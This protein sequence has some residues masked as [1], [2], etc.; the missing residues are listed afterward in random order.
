MA[1]LIAIGK[2]EKQQWWQSI[3]EGEEVL[4]GRAPRTGWS[5]PWDRLISREHAY[6][7][8][9]DDQLE[10]RELDTA[11]NPIFFEG[12]QRKQFFVD[13]DC[14]FRIGETTFRF[15]LHQPDPSHKPT[16]VEHTLARE[17]V[18]TP[19]FQNA[20]SCLEALC[21]MPKMIQGART[22]VEFASQI[23]DLLLESLAGAVA[24][25]VM[26]YEVDDAAEV[27]DPVLMRWNSREGAV[28]R[29]RPSRRLVNRAFDKK[30]S[31]M[32]LWTEA[33][34][35][36][37]QFTMNDD[38][39]WAFC[40]PIATCSNERWCLYVSGKRQFTGIQDVESPEDLMGE[41][42]LAELMAH[43][44]GAIRNLR[45]LEHQHSSMKQFFS[46]AV[47]ETLVSKKAELALEPRE[48][49]VSVLFCDIRGFSRKVE[50]SREELPLLLSRVSEAL[51]V[52]T[53]SILKFE[54]VI[55]DFQGDAAL[56]FWGWPTEMDDS[57]VHACRAALAIQAAFH[58]A[59][60]DPS[61]PL[62]GFQIGIGVGHGNAVAGR[63]GSQEQIKVGVFG[64]V[65]NLA[66]RLQDLTKAMGVP[67]LVD[68]QTAQVA[69]KALDAS[70]AYC[71]RVAYL[72]PAGVQSSVNAYALIPTSDEELSLTGEQLRNH[73]S[74]VEAVIASEWETAKALLQQMPLTDGPSNFLR[75]ALECI[76]DTPEDWDGAINMQD[77]S[78]HQ[79]M[80]Y[81]RG[82]D[83]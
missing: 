77:K 2:D 21:K 19:M 61:N 79:M 53:R 66:S 42:R 28:N 59:A 11:R 33:A 67:I 74:I 57:A 24:V 20:S 34:A 3:P 62:H 27:T 13:P 12:A 16:V 54:G 45:S 47:V 73:Q 71:R 17:H 80:A 31:V 56:G 30:Q 1:E 36:N 48:G 39:D 78:G 9:V 29:F 32:H 82:N 23:V 14:E 70:E 26:Q 69:C 5:V 81:R 37:T 76:G 72:R 65:V 15:E 7:R 58:E 8:L 50:Q 64:P 75:S 4:L 43:F 49:P 18:A 68:E 52:M 22:D 40:T 46:P 83:K 63:I 44:L 35:D 38:L 10:V 55:A 25:A 60:D 51:S 6:V 41:L